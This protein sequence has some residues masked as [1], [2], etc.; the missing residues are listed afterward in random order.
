MNKAEKAHA[1]AKEILRIN[2]KFS[3]DGLFADFRF[4]CYEGDQK[5]VFIN[6]L[7]DAGLK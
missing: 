2:P 1:E 4:G 5:D 3:F 6:A 7:R